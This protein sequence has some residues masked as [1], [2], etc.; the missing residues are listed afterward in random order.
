MSAFLEMQEKSNKDNEILLEMLINWLLAECKKCTKKPF[1]LHHKAIRQFLKSKGISLRH[2]H[3]VRR[4]VKKL[5][6]EVPTHQMVEKESDTTDKK[7][8]KFILCREV[9][10]EVLLEIQNPSYVSST[11][12]KSILHTKELLEKVNKVE[13]EIEGALKRAK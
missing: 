8:E 11:E 3:I 4:K 5:S 7:T 1:S 10:G 13:L 12:W 2:N 6:R 9:D